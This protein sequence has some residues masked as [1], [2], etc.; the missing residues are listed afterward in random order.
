MYESLQQSKK[1]K[2]KCYQP[3]LPLLPIAGQGFPPLTPPRVPEPDSL[4][5]VWLPA[6]LC[7]M[8][9]IVG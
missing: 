2:Q 8:Q 9:S 4:V 3:A 7:W 6:L 1:Q 5:W